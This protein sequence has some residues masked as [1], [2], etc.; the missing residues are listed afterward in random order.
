MLRTRIKGQLIV[1][2]YS[3]VPQM[4]KYS[5][6]GNSLSALAGLSLNLCKFNSLVYSV[7]CSATDVLLTR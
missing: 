5:T 7:V 4:L 2:R 6:K 3:I 1:L